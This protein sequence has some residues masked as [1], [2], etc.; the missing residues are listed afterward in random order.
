[1]VSAQFSSNGT[2]PMAKKLQK[3]DRVL[4]HIRWLEAPYIGRAALLVERDGK[5]GYVPATEVE[6][7]FGEFVPSSDPTR[8]EKFAKEQFSWMNVKGSSRHR[9]RSANFRS[10]PGARER[11]SQKLG[12][13]Q[14]RE[15]P[16]LPC[17]GNR[18]LSARSAHR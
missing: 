6:Q 17:L 8:L 11:C 5:V 4:A 18:S 12:E 3:G 15:K 13:I 7:R 16:R 2:N 10:R 9:E 1:L 14:P